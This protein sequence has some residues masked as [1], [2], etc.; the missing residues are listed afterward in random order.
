MLPLVEVLLLVVLLL[1]VAMVSDS[2]CLRDLAG[3]VGLE[4]NL[5]ELVYFA[6]GPSPGK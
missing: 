3:E 5:G 1:D 6:R 4:R 2:A